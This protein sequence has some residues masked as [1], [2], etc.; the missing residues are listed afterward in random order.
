MKYSLHHKPKEWVKELTLKAG[1]VIRYLPTQDQDLMKYQLTS[2][3]NNL[4]KKQGKLRSNFNNELEKY[5]KKNYK[6]N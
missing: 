1:T 6:T 4:H 3:I 2:N 5:R